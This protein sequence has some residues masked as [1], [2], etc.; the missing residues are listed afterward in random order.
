MEKII[1]S[2]TTHQEMIV[3]GTLEIGDNTEVRLENMDNLTIIAGNCNEIS[4]GKNCNITCGEE[5]VIYGGNEN[6]IITGA[7]CTI[8]CVLLNEVETK[9]YCKIMGCDENNIKC[10]DCC[11]V[12]VTDGNK[13]TCGEDCVIYGGNENKIT[14]KSNSKAFIGEDCKIKLK[15]KKILLEIS[16]KNAKVK[17]KAKNSGIITYNEKGKMK[18]YKT[19]KLKKGVV[20]VEKG[21]F[22][23][24]YDNRYTTIEN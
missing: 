20:K 1:I 22:S 23:L 8:E 10:L 19:N 21:E 12:V 13:V 11:E 17:N 15:G 18:M 3:N 16:G 14:I 7:N 4:V 2:E 6:K 24:D 9:Q 5:C